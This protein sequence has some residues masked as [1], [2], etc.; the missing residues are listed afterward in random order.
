MEFG[1]KCLLPVW[2]NASLVSSQISVESSRKGHKINKAR[3]SSGP[4]GYE[5]LNLPVANVG[6]TEEKTNFFCFGI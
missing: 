1:P 2:G 3:I 6:K 5:N 4:A